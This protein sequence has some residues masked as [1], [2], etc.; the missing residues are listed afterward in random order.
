M[1]TGQTRRERYTLPGDGLTDEDLRHEVEL[2]RQE[3]G[4]T[5]ARLLYKV[6]VPART[7][8]A[9]HTKLSQA[10]DT[11][12]SARRHPVALGGLLAGLSALVALWI[13][14]RR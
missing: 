3:L 9:M 11:A 12:S 10:K 5:V 2:T 13:W 7:R 4:S 6:D 14:I 1:T 8:D